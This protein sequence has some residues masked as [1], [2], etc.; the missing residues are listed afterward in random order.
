MSSGTTPLGSWG[1]RLKLSA[2]EVVLLVLA[3]YGGLLAA[4]ASHKSQYYSLENRKLKEALHEFE[5][6]DPEKIHVL[7]LDNLD[8]ST[9]RWRIWVPGPEY[10][11]SVTTC[12]LDG[13]GNISPEHPS[14][15][16]VDQLVW[17]GNE[18]TFLL[19][20]KI[21]A[22]DDSDSAMGLAWLNNQVKPPIGFYARYEDILVDDA[23]GLQINEEES[24]CL[25][26]VIDT[27]QTA[28]TTESGVRR[29]LI[30]KLE[31]L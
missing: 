29:A 31:Q 22:E 17:K 18:E 13:Q 30:V 4:S 8:R 28:R 26:K 19:Y 9:L 10:H 25:L 20:A 7:R 3:I 2:L 24:V 11:V 21:L 1:K 27:R 23:D 5:V 15:T 14:H 6:L 16:Q 12:Y